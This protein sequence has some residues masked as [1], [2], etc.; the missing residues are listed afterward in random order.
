MLWLFL[1]VAFGGRVQNVAFN[2][3]HEKVP[4]PIEDFM[5]LSAGACS[6]GWCR[7]R[8]RSGGTGRMGAMRNGQPLQG[9]LAVFLRLSGQRLLCAES[10]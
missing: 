1:H 8:N 7:L 10:R 4:L 2:E 3:G 9:V 5:P 6:E